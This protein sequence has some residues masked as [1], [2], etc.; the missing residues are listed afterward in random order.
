MICSTRTDVKG[1]AQSVGRHAYPV[2]V[3][4]AVC[5]KSVELCA[6]LE[7]TV[8]YTHSA[9]RRKKSACNAGEAGAAALYSMIMVPVQTVGR[10]L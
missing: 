10:V 7:A 1:L 6:S 3:L 4:V 9:G 5:S 8:M 2:A